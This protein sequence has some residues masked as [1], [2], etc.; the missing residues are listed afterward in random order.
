MN[1]VRFMSCFNLIWGVNKKNP[2]GSKT[3]AVMAN[4]VKMDVHS[5][6]GAKGAKALVRQLDLI[7]IYKFV[8]IVVIILFIS[9]FFGGGGG[10]E[11]VTKPESQFKIFLAI[12]SDPYGCQ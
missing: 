11:S 12:F 7:F 5:V 6:W 10:R 3:I 2:G 9:F 8:F 1:S 4:V